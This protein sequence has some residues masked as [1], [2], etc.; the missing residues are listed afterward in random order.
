MRG[1]SCPIKGPGQKDPFHENTAS[2]RCCWGTIIIAGAV[3]LFVL[4]GILK[5]LLRLPT[6]ASG[7]RGESLRFSDAIT[8]ILI[9]SC[10]CFTPYI[11]RAREY[12]AY[13]RKKLG[14]VLKGCSNS[15]STLCL[16][17]GDTITR[18]LSW[19]MQWHRLSKL[20]Q[21]DVMWTFSY[22]IKLR[23]VSPSTVDCLS[24]WTMHGVWRVNN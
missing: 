3:V 18:K 12:L 16:V 9:C 6:R 17:F 11:S 8:Y 20:T 19:R 4:G 10:L 21:L 23:T 5:A 1:A 22:K 13:S 7:Q 14:F 2:N 15:H 24:F